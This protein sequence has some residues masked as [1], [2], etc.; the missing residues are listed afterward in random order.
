MTKRFGSGRAA[1]SGLLAAD[2]AK[3]GFTGPT[4]IIEG[5]WGYLRAYSDRWDVALVTDGL[6]KNLYP[7]GDDLQ[8]LP[9]LQSPPCAIDGVLGLKAQTPMGL[10]R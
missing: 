2:L 5:D 9:L 7:H 6:G 1:Q 4:S 8:A 3:L 10:S